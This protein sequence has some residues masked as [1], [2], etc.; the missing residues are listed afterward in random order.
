MLRNVSIL[1]V[2]EGN[3]KFSYGTDNMLDLVLTGSTPIG[4]TFRVG[5]SIASFN[6]DG[7]GDN[8]Y[9]DQPGKLQQECT[10]CSRQC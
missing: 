9:L 6:R 3:V 5:G 1:I 7:F 8:L 2:T 4:D 10:G